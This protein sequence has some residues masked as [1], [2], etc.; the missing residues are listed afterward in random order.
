MRDTRRALRWLGKRQERTVTVRELHRGPVG[1]QG[2]VEQAEARL[3]K[4]AEAVRTGLE[5]ADLFAQL[6]T[7]AAATG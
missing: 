5:M 3:D 6:R 1:S 7:A 2:P 4:G